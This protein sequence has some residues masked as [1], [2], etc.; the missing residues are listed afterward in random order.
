V[1]HRLSPRDGHDWARELASIDLR[2]PLALRSQERFRPSPGTRVRALLRRSRLDRALARG[3][4]PRES[5]ALAYR[6][7]RLTSPRS[8]EKLSAWVDAVLVRAGSPT[9]P[10]S[11]AVEA[12][13][14]EVWGAAAQLAQLRELLRSGVPIYA[15]GVAMLAGLLRDGGSA[16]Y[17]PHWRGQLSHE[18]E[19]IIGALE[20]RDQSAYL[21]AELH[22][23]ED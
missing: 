20:G 4:D 13:R 1:A 10:R 8:R 17:L 5:P 14:G 7:A 6:A 15:R 19:L 22:D 12:D 9:R 3:A 23:G 21:R 18:L 2:D 11:V 16:V